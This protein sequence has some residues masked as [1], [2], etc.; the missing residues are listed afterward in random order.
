[1]LPSRP[2]PEGTVAR[3]TALRRAEL[4]IGALADKIERASLA[5][6]T[7]S[8]RAQREVQDHPALRLCHRLVAIVRATLDEKKRSIPA[9]GW[10]AI[11]FSVVTKMGSSGNSVGHRVEIEAAA[12]EVDGGLEVLAIAEPVGALLDRLDLGVEAFA[13]GV[14]DP[15]GEVGH[16]VRQ[17]A[18]DQASGL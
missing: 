17:V 8:A 4:N 7:E 6:Q 3:E 5:L 2:S 15:V 9:S 18:L 14:G 13:H 11:V 12:V 16:H 10:Q 1:M